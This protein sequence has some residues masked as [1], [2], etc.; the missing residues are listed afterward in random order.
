MELPELVQ[1]MSLW[2]ADFCCSWFGKCFKG[3][4]YWDVGLS[5]WPLTPQVLAAFMTHMHTHRMWKYIVECQQRE[6]MRSR[7]FDNG[8]KKRCRYLYFIFKNSFLWAS[9]IPFR[10]RVNRE[11]L[12]TQP[13]SLKKN[14]NFSCYKIILTMISLSLSLDCFD[15]EIIALLSKLTCFCIYFVQALG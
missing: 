3:K 2:S 13:A 12:L 4:K 5:L 6:E 11:E 8:C 7:R 10:A 9:L 15:N 14:F 1:P